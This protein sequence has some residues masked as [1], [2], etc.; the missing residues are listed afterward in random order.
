MEKLLDKNIDNLSFEDSYERLNQILEI[1]EKG[2]VSLDDSIKYYEQGIKLKTH[3]ENKLKTAELKIQK[4]IE[5]NKI[6][7]LDE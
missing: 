5:N 2:N 6:K 3:C 7:N 4:V 1:L